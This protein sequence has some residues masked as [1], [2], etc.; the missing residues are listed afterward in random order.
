MQIQT[1]PVSDSPNN[2]AF[3]G[4][5]EL[6]YQITG[7]ITSVG[8]WFWVY[9]PVKKQRGYQDI[10]VLAVNATETVIVSVT[11]NLDDKINTQNG[12]INIEKMAKL[13]EHFSRVEKYL[14]EVPQYQWLA[15]KDIKYVVAYIGAAKRTLPFVTEELDKNGIHLVSCDSMFKVLKCHVEK[16]NIKVQNQVLRTV[17]IMH[18]YLPEQN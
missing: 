14:C 3:E 16:P 12:L 7:H 10:D 1:I 15:T 8:K 13:K 2:D 4:I 6:Y 17:Q 18:K 5:V 11:S 9:D